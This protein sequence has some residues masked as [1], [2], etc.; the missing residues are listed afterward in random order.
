MIRNVAP[1]GLFGYSLRFDPGICIPGYTI[2]VAPR[3]MNNA[4]ATG[5]VGQKS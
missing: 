1:L 3:L 5:A 2:V 4:I